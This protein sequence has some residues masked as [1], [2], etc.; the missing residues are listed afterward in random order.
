MPTPADIRR[1]ITGE[2]EPEQFSYPDYPDSPNVNDW[3]DL[4][5]EQRDEL[6]R[7]LATAKKNLAGPVKVTDEPK[8]VDYSHWNRMG[9]EQK[10]ACRQALIASHKHMARGRAE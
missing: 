7:N 8:G 4:T 6:E 3:Q 9:D 10:E 2:N 1:I 5:Q